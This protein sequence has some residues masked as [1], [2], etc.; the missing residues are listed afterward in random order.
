M[1]KTKKKKGFD[2]SILFSAI[3]AIVCYSVFTSYVGTFSK[4]SG[5]SMSPTLK[6]KQLTYINK[7]DKEY[8]RND[9]VAVKRMFSG[10]FI[11]KRVIGLPGETIQIIDGKVYINNK[12]YEDDLFGHIIIEHSGEFAKPVTLKENEYFILGDNRNNSSDSTENG[13]YYYNEILGTLKY[14]DKSK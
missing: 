5:E 13:P 2:Y 12:L 14:K 11:V 9:V 1:N 8:E 4:I 7:L 3:F 6:D 10:Y